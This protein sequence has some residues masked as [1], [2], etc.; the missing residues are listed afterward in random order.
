V[1]PR[2]RPRPECKTE[3]ETRKNCYET[4]RPKT[5]KYLYAFIVDDIFEIINKCPACATACN[6]HQRTDIMIDKIA[7][8]VNVDE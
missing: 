7:V 2:P 8:T 1:R 4:T 3:T 6:V 5:T